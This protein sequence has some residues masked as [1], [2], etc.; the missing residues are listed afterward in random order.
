MHKHRIS[1]VERNSIAQELGIEAGDYLV[2]IDGLPVL[3]VLDYRYRTACQ[4]LSAT[5]VSESGQQLTA[6]IEKDAD[7]DLGLV[8]EEPLLSN[9]RSCANR[10]VFC[11]VDQLPG[12]VRQALRFKDDDWRLSFLQGNFVTL[13]NVSDAELSRI[14]KQRVSPLNISVQ[15]TDEALRCRMMRNERAAGI[16][17]QLERLS[18][19]KIDFYAQIV[20]CPGWN[21]GE[22]LTQTLTDLAAYR[23]YAKGVAIVPVGLT[24]YRQGLERMRAVTKEDAL[25]AIERVNNFEREHGEGFVHLADEF[26][27]L[28]EKPIPPREAYGDFAQLEDGVGLLRCF[29]DDFC[30]ALADVKGGSSQTLSIATGEASY[31]VIRALCDQAEKELGNTIYVYPIRN[32]FFGGGVSVTGLLTGKCLLEGLAGKELGERLLLCSSMTRDR[33]EVFLDDM[34]VD[35]LS[36]R[37]DIDIELVENN[38]ASLLDA[39][40]TERK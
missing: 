29:M 4:R 11:F 2:E 27:L 24:A 40:N 22:Q 13:T 14:I 20:L 1:A 25:D 18:Q 16:G 10:C 37:L 28:C 33:D 5:F 8:F 17:R 6:D 26:Y 39:L 36:K 3:D 32:S 30:D 34:T 35:E 12:H 15:T 9:K 21:D 7:E 31:S 23:P 38:G 19:A